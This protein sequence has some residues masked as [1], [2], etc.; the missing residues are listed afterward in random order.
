MPSFLRPAPRP[1]PRARGLFAWLSCLAFAGWACPT[2]AQGRE[3][4]ALTAIRLEPAPDMAELSGRPVRRVEVTQTPGR[5]RSPAKVASVRTGEP[6][7]GALAR[8]A[9]RELLESGW[10]SNVRIAARLDGDGVVLALHATPRRLMATRRLIGAA[11]DDSDV[12]RDSPVASGGELTEELL[13]RVG[14]SV[15]RYHAGRGYPGAK[16]RVET[17]DTD[18]PMRVVLVVEVE[19]GEP[20]RVGSRTVLLPAALRPTLESVVD[21]YAV[22]R[23]DLADEVA[24]VEADQK[25]AEQLRARHHPRARLTHRTLVAGASAQLFVYVEP[26]PLTRLRFEGNH[27]VDADQLEDAVDYDKEADR[28]PAH[29]ATKVLAM[30]R[31]LGLHDATVEVE[32]RGGPSDAI[33]DIVFKI[34]EGPV[35]RVVARELP[36]LTGARGA[37]EVASEI[38]SFLE[39]A[40][41]GA[42]LLGPV[43]PAA[44]DQTLGPLGPTGA[45]PAPLEAVPARTFVP[46]VYDKAVKHLQDL[47]RSEGYLSA[48]VGPV[49]VIRRACDARSPPGQ[50]VPVPAP[51]VPDAACVYDP[52]G[53]P[54]EEPELGARF[55]C[56]P[57]RARG[58]AC[59][60]RLAVRIPIKL[61]PRSTLWDLA[62]DGNRTLLDTALAEASELVLG[63]PASNLE[64][65]QARRRVLDEYREAGFAYAE[66]RAAFELSP[67]HTRARARFS[68]SE[69]EQVIVDRI[70]IQGAVRTSESLVRGR[71]ALEPGKPYR[72]SLIRKTE[73]RIATLG[74]FSS[75]AV[76][77]QDPF[78]PAKRKTVIVQ[79]QERAPQYLDIRL[80]FSTG[81][82]FRIQF[83]Y[84]HRNI[85]GEAIQ[86]T[87]RIRLG[88]LP[89]PFI[90]DPD[91]RR[92]LDT[93]PVSQR[94][95][96]L[97]TASVLFPEIGLGPL[98]SLGVDGIDVRR[99]ARDFGLSKN[100]VS[101]ALHYRPVRVL[102]TS[103]GVSLERN[104]VA[105]FNGQTVQEYLSRPGV[106]ADL[107]R[108]LRVPDG[109]T[110]AV[111]ERATAAWDRRDNPFGATRG[112]L[113]GGVVEHVRAFPAS[114]NP[115]SK[116]SDFLRV[117]GTFAGYVKLSRRGLVLAASVRGGRILQL[118][119]DSQTYP[120]RLFF[121]GGVDSLRGFLQDSLVP[122]DLADRIQRDAAYAAYDPARL[123]VQQVAIRG[124]DVF[125]N[126]RAELRIP[127]STIVQTALFLDT[128]NVWVEPRNFNPLV[129]RYASGSGLRVATPIG[130]IA[131]DYGINL[132][133]RSWEDFGAFHFSI[134]LF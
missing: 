53:L 61:G 81:E 50:C 24:L 43:D 66:V 75:I 108:L 80:G 42:G 48:M 83:E 78:V 111:A 127:L 131:F 56:R 69:S 35:V 110:Y 119:D 34:R 65:E 25:M 1:P 71:V 116:L 92:N 28:S 11:F 55:G 132:A 27:L 51:P 85:A 20:V 126:P 96:R 23:G 7:S 86:F 97:N 118:L 107:G 39:E 32:E 16:V 77:L 125:L 113:L 62:F 98:I 14:E 6:M 8:R 95:E 9:A 59:E 12:W 22:D 89:D 47:F 21:G 112:T 36:C 122:Q 37:S 93:L 54:L 68:A 60:P 120:D 5:W 67:D 115:N 117:S 57:D 130:P 17:R 76:S 74:T 41:P 72:T 3:E 114:D 104:D 73:E 88:Y 13:A 49:Q 103:L 45:R 121:L 18:D 70:V 10:F 30:Y 33:N 2:L 15:R 87:F 94:M 124:G 100:A 79:V 44:I 19:P 123:T 58:L 63:A 84:G 102:A 109:L 134:G 31:S 46:E 90:L 129:L 106:T 40:L 133:R 38:D 26:G 128:G 99:N 4:S 101:S 64:L 105:I 91:V 82:G 29:L 52:R